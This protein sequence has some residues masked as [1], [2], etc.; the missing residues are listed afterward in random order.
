LANA[1]TLAASLLSAG[2]D[3]VSGG[4]DNHLILV[5]LDSWNITG[6]D[7]EQALGKAGITVNK[8]A[9]PFDKRGPQVTSG[10]RIG[11]PFVTSRG[12]NTEEMK[13]IAA[14]IVN[15]LQH[16]DDEQVL[17]QSRIRVT[18][19]CNSHPIYQ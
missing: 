16:M 9:V 18:E 5:D 10:I 17:E 15:V 7:A 3:L 13:Q 8:N 6:R 14:I 19:L 1:Q 2:L 11:T 12:M 4:T